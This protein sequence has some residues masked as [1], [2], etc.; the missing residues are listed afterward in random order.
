MA[1]SFNDGPDVAIF[2]G[3]PGRSD[4]LA[5][6][7]RARGCRVVLYNNGGTPGAYVPLHHSLLPILFRVFSTNHQVYFTPL[8]FVPSLCLCLNRLLRGSPCVLNATG[9]KSATYRERSSRW[10][11]RRAA[12]VWLYPALMKWIMARAGWIIC[13]SRYLQEQ[14]NSKFP[15]HAHKISTIYNGIEFDRFASG[16]GLTA[17]GI[18]AKSPQLLAVMTWNYRGKAEGAKLLIDSMGLITKQCPEAR[19]VIAAK[20][21]HDGYAQEIEAY[22]AGKSW[23][24]SVKILYNQTNIPDLLAS[25]DLFLYAAAAE[26]NDSLPRA[27]L[28]AH[29]AGLPIVTTATSGCPEIVEDSISGFVVPYDE[30]TMAERVIELLAHPN[31]REEMARAG[32]K[33]VTKLFSWDLMGREYADLFLRL[34]SIQREIDATNRLIRIQ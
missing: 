15:R 30:T 20:T 10:P 32:R 2:F 23:K 34:I 19:L 17:G 25:S 28:E 14:L 31:K 24:D 11:F 3:R 22:L 12:E 26:S 6:Q 9:L 4:I 16:R 5:E 8:S 27:L 33:R 13:N 18:P 1:E 29:A 7:L 21:M